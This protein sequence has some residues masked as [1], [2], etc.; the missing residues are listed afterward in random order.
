[1]PSEA[2]IDPF[3]ALERAFKQAVKSRLWFLITGSFHLV[4]LLRQ[5]VI[6]K[7]PHRR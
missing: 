1:M 4:G 5:S 6:A 3:E 7:V 2:T